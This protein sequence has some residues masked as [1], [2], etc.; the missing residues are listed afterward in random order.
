MIIRA[1]IQG[2]LWGTSPRDWAQ[3]QEG[4]SIP[5]WEAALTTLRVSSGTRFLD[6]GCGAGGACAIALRR[7]ARVHGFDASAGLLAC[8]RERIARVDFRQ[9]DLE[10]LPYPD[11]SFD[12]VLAANSLQYCRNVAVA[13]RELRRVCERRGAVAVCVWGRAED[14]EMREV[15]A[16]VGR[17]LPQSQNGDD[18]FALSAP[19]MLE[20]LIEK[21]G[22]HVTDRGQ[23]ECPFYYADVATLWR[24]VRSSGPLEAAVRIAGEETIKN[25]VLDAVEP[26]RTSGGGVRLDNTF[27]YVIARP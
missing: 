20:G 6:A 11:A 1:D 19:G 23:A 2:E 5:L 13:L 7:G 4:F 15:F 10:D 26:F 3:I 25:A 8:A 14:C 12:A 9:G 27:V 24:G 17:A 18:P 22:L 16:A 21:A